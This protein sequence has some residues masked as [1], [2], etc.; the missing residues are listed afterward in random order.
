MRNYLLPIFALLIGFTTYAQTTSVKGSIIDTSGKKNLQ[1]AVVSLLKKDS[2]L[3]AFTRAD[4]T[5]N[6]L[7]QK[8]DTGHTIL[9]ISFPGFADFAEEIYL[10]DIPVN[11]LGNFALT[12]K[13]RL[14]DAV[15]IRSAG[16]IRIK[17]DT[18]EFVA[19]S[20]HVRE[21][22][23]VEEL[24]KKLPG[25][26][27]NSKGEIK[28]QGQRVQ[29]VLV[30]GEE[31]FGDD[32]TMATKNL[33]AK[34]VDKVQ[35]YDN[36][37][38][39]QNLT[40]VSSGNEGKTVN[41]KLKEDQKKGALG[42]VEAGTDFNE[43]VDAKLLYN[44]FKGKRKL[45][46][47]GTRTTT[48][49][50][51]LNW[52]DSRTLGMENDFEYDEISG[53]YMS[54]GGSDDDFNNWNYRGIPDAYTAGGLFI[55]RWNQDKHGVN[56]TYRYNRLGTANVTDKRIQSITPERFFNTST[57][58]RSNGLNQ[59]HAGKFMYEWKP[60]SLKTIKLNVGVTYRNNDVINQTD[61]TTANP[62][63]L[64]YTSNKRNNELFTIKKQVESQLQYKQYFKKKNRILMSTLRLGVIA[65]DQDGYVFSDVRYYS[66]LGLD[67]S[68]LVKQQK[69]NEG[70]SNTIG[71]K[72]TFSE[73]LGLKWTLISEYS[74]NENF[75]SSFRQTFDTSLSGK[76]EI[77]NP[78]LSNHFDLDAFSNSGSLITRYQYKK[79]RLAFGSALSSIKLDLNNLDSNKK[80]IYRFSNF[81]PQLSFGYTP[82]QQTHV[83]INYRGNTVQP[84]INQLQPLFDNNDPLNIYVGN[85]LLRVGFKHNLS[86]FYNNYKVLSSRGIWVSAGINV[87]DD[88]IS[89]FSR[90]DEQT[91]ARLYGPV[92]VEGNHDYYFWGEWN[93]GE[94]EKKFIHTGRFSGNGG[95]NV[96]I[97]NS[98]RN[99]NNYYK[100]E[101]GYGIRY[102]AEEKYKIYLSPKLGVN[103]SESSLYPEQDNKYL[104]YGGEVEG[105]LMLPGKLEMN[106]QCYFELRQRTDLF[107]G[108]PNV[109]TWNVFLFKKIFKDKTGKIIF[110]ANDI[111][112]QNRGYTR[113]INSDRVSEESFQRISRYFMIKFEW[114]FNKMGGKN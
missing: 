104:N 77:L 74:H 81:I 64:K 55:D 6:F 43:I 83:G 2:T 36:K 50:G 34:S 60:D 87:T 90:I 110:V 21:G 5:G 42:K 56:A 29:K 13:A 17:G 84:S 82:K 53:Y 103:N 23:T 1:H 68:R 27:V 88:A 98:Q 44:R 14:L 61:D 100:V 35:V 22:A 28:A 107:Q 49:T 41:I 89:Q 3:H 19:D 25:F 80:V 93:K 105:Y 63:L 31:F 91:G 75:S 33:S 73:P 94:G 71:A 4:K 39:Q 54:F 109:I 38:E 48:S 58:T 57:I 111:L 102:E 72:I 113:V 86:L 59:Q 46:L 106:T 85:P 78:Y 66:D 37:T 24:L 65:D 47:Y 51:S 76:Y 8:A 108:N 101:V 45:S 12:P 52:Q 9:L 11:E 7:I 95:R 97:V 32:P 99:I 20:F 15:I 62:S 69:T 67:S 40:G 92:N 26:Q 30:D 18:T 112:D 10:K 114:S 70:S 96:T 79:F 16:A